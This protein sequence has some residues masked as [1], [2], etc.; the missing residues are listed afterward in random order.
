MGVHDAAPMVFGAFDGSW[1]PVLPVWA[2]SSTCVNRLIKKYLQAL[3]STASTFARCSVIANFGSAWQGGKDK[4]PWE[5]EDESPRLIR[6]SRLPE[7]F[8]RIT[9]P[10]AWEDDVAR[11]LGY[12]VH[13]GQEGRL[14]PSRVLQFDLPTEP[15]STEDDVLRVEIHPRSTLRYDAE[16]RLYV[17]RLLANFPNDML[18]QCQLRSQLPPV[19]VE[20][21][22][23]LPLTR[24]QQEDALAHAVD[25]ETRRLLGYMMDYELAGPVWV[26]AVLSRYAL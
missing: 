12:Y 2:A 5:S 26:S 22:A 24:E 10:D 4:V 13:D 20:E 16:S 6:A 19:P 9:N 8:L 14:T 18:A 17:A 3:W 1:K 21:E 25:Q 7:D 11:R 23:Y 15:D